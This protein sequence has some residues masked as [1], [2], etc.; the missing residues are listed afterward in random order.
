MQRVALAA[1]TVIRLLFRAGGYDRLPSAARKGGPWTG[2]F[3]GEMARLKPEYRLAIA[4]DGY[5]R[6]EGLALGFS[7]E[8]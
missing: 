6:I 7:A 8:V 3:T 5:V 2:T 4:R 1:A